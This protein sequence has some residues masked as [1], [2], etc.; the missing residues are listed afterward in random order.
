[1]VYGTICIHVWHIVHDWIHIINV[2]VGISYCSQLM[3][4]YLCTV[5]AWYGTG[6]G[7]TS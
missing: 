3:H 6:F 5:D 4:I 1:M 7:I 2:V